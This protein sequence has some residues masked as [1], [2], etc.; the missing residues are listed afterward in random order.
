MLNSQRLQVEQSQLREK[1]NKTFDN[2]EITDDQRADL[3]KLTTRAQAI[4]LELRAALTAEGIETA[5]VT[6]PVTEPDAEMRERLE[7]RSRA[8]LTNYL[9]AAMQGRM[10]AG[11]EAEL[12]AAAGIDSGV[13]LELWDTPL[14]T[15][16]DTVSGAP[17]TVGVNLDPLRPMIFAPSIAGRLGIDMPRVSSG[18]YAT[19]TLTTPLTAAAK[20]AGGDAESTAAAFTVSTAT[21]KRISARLSV[22]IEDV[23]AVGQANFESILRENLSLVLSDALDNAAIN[24]DGEAPNLAGIF[25]ALTTPDNPTAIAT[26]DS[27]AA[28]H[29]GGIE[30]LWANTLMDVSIVC[31]PATYQLA[32]KTFQS[33]TNYKGEL[34]AAAYARA[35]T[36]GLWT[37][38]RM[39]DAVSNI[40]Q[41]ILYRKGR[42]GI[43][44]A[45]C[46]HWNNLMID[47]IYTSSASGERH[48]TAHVLL[49]DV[50]I[51][52]PDA[53]AQVAYKLA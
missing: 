50:A 12:Q 39:P 27:F 20:S 17:S 4:E 33:A 32:A 9:T 38:K 18:T 13:P 8:Q 19:G 41:G 6:E 51:V 23:A 22:R 28:V 43:R 48:L 29:A 7:L 10:P 15:G 30:G 53:Y 44:T 42:T 21:P 5:A 26:F 2:G 24:G 25:Q 3:D 46:P 47:D 1:I 11:A 49:G 37:N 16:A 34:S 52:Q 40:Q 14:E 36:G 31:G 35:N 45:V